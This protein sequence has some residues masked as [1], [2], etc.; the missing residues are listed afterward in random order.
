MKSVGGIIIVNACIWGLVMI[1]CAL[2]LKG[3]GAFEKIQHIRG[4]GA[5][6]SMLS[7][8]LLGMGIRRNRQG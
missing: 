3:T 8:L 4:G 6:F 1:I 2:A 7:I 5:A